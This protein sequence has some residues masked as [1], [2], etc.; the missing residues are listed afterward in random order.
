M[1]EL[2]GHRKYS[3]DESYEV[4]ENNTLSQLFPLDD[5]IDPQETFDLLKLKFDPLLHQTH[6][7]NACFRSHK[8]KM[9]EIYLKFNE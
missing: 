1:Y 5:N 8:T 3:V 2:G 9:V 7:I 6:L 4:D